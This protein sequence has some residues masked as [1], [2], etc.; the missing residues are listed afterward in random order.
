MIPTANLVPAGLQARPEVS[1][2][3]STAFH[4]RSVE[5]LCESSF[6]LGLQ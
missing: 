6:F 5:L 3:L 2:P 1:A 4:F